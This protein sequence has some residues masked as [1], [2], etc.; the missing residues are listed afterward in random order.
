MQYRSKTHKKVAAA[1]R[2]VKKHEPK[3]VAHT[4]AKFG[5]RRAA[6]QETAIALN[7][8]RKAGARIPYKKRPHGSG[9]FQ[10]NEIRQGYRK[11]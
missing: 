4:R 8:A 10:D 9:V 11:L 7:K 3:A 6:A 1:F 2:E 5:A